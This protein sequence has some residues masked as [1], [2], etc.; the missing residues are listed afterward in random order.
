MS[1]C[2]TAMHAANSAVIAPT[3]ATTSSAPSP[4]SADTLAPPDT[5]PPPPS[6]P[7]ESARSP[8]SALPSH[9]AATRAAE[10]APTSHCSAENQQSNRRRN[11]HAAHR[12]ARPSPRS[13]PAPDTPCPG[14]R[15][16]ASQ[17]CAVEP[18]HPDQQSQIANPRCDERLLRCRCRCRPMKPEPDQQVRRQPYHLPAHKEQQQAV[19]NHHAQHRARKQGEET[20]EPREFSSWAM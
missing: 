17:L 14:C 11:R 16:A 13:R 6:S 19:R 15:T 1:F 20:E 12:H 7:R 8:V 4:S 18:H 5:R 9:P 3:H 10:P 2:A